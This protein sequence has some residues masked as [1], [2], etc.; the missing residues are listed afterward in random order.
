MKNKELCWKIV[1]I[2]LVIGGLN[3]GL[4]GIGMLSNSELNVVHLLLDKV[5]T[6]EAVVYLLVGLAALKKAVYL[7]MG[8]CKGGKCD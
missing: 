5:P 8:K 4:V 7:F 6:G 3:W 2:L 1:I